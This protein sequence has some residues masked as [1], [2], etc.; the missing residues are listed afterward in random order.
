[1]PSTA[2]G[3]QFD[4]YDLDA[5]YEVVGTS[6]NYSFQYKIGIG[7]DLV[8]NPN[9]TA[10]NDENHFETVDQIV[11]LRGNYG[12]FEIRIFAVSN[13]GVRSEFIQDSIFI[14]PPSFDGTFTFNNLKINDLPE[15]SNL[16]NEIT[17]APE[18][19]GSTLEVSS[20]FINR[21]INL[22]WELIPPIGHEL[23]GE[24]VSDKLLSDDFFDHFKIK[25][26]NGIDNTVI[27]DSN[28]NSSVSLQ[29]KLLTANVA[30][31]LNFYRDFSIELDENTFSAQEL[32]LERNLSFEI[33]AHDSRGGVCTGIL[34]GINF[35]PDLNAT[36]GLSNSESSFSFSS[37]DTDF[38]SVE[39]RYIGIP[40]DFGLFDYRDIEN[41]VT[42][43]TRLNNAKEYVSLKNQRFIKN[44]SFVLFEGDVYKAIQTHLNSDA[45]SPPNTIYWENVG[46]KFAFS[47]GVESTSSNSF[48]N[49]QIFGYDYYYSFKPFDGYGPNET[50]NFTEERNL[51]KSSENDGILFPVRSEIKIDSLSFREREDDL[52]FNWSIVDQDGLPVELADQKYL[53]NFGDTQK[54]LGISGHLFDNHNNE[55]LSGIAS[56]EIIDNFEYTRDINNQIYKNGGFPEN[57][58]DFNITEIYTPDDKDMVISDFDFSREYIGEDSILLEIIA[59]HGGIAG[60][61]GS[62]NNKFLFNSV[63]QNSAKQ[64]YVRPYYELWDVSKTYYVNTTNPLLTDI[65]AYQKTLYEAVADSGPESDD[66]IGIFNETLNYSQGDLVISPTSAVQI[67]DNTLSYEISETVL[68]EGNIYSCLDDQSIGNAID[69]DLDSTKWKLQSPF[70]DVPC[71]IY[72]AIFPVAAQSVT[73]FINSQQDQNSIVWVPQYPNNSDKFTVCV[74][75]YSDAP[76]N[77]FVY[78]DEMVYKRNN[79]SPST[80]PPI[81]LASLNQDYTTLDWTPFWEINDNFENVVFGHVGIPQSGKRSVGLEIGIVSV[82][83]QVVS[84]DQII[85]DNPAPVISN[86]GFSVDSQS[87]VTKVKFNFNYLRGR[88][89]KTTLLNLYRSDQPDF[90]ITG[91]DGLPFTGI[92]QTDSTFVKSVLGEGDATFGDNITQIVDDTA[93]VGEEITGYYYK[94]LPFDD[95]GSG[96][97]YTAVDDEDPIEKVWVLP[98]NFHDRR[99]GA[100]PGPAIEITTDEIPG[101]VGNLNGETAFENYFLNWDM[102]NG[103]IQNGIFVNDVPNDISYYE[104]WQSSGQSNNFLQFS[105]GSFLTEEQNATGYRRINVVPN[106]FGNNIPDENEDFANGIVNASNVLDID[107]R[108]RSIQVTHRGEVNDTSYFWVRPVDHAGNKGPFTGASDL[109]NTDN[110]EGLKLILGQANTTDIADFEQNISQS[111]PNTISL[112]PQNPFSYDASTNTTSWINHILYYDGVGYIV[113]AGTAVDQRYI[114][115]SSSRDG[116][117]YGDV[118]DSNNPEYSRN[119]ALKTA[120]GLEEPGGGAQTNSDNLRNVEKAGVYNSSDYHPAGAGDSTEVANGDPY[121]N[122]EKPNL[123][124]PEGDFI[125]ARIAGGTVTTMWHS[126]ANATIG[127]AHIEEAAITSA[128]VHTLTADKIRSAEIK[129]QDIQVGGTGQI[130]SVNFPGL[131]NPIQN[132]PQGFAVSGD[133]TFIFAA[134]DGRLHFDDGELVLEGKLRQ[135]DGKEYTFIDLDASPDSFFYNELS[136]GTFTP[137]DNTDVCN[138]RASFQNSFIQAD[139]VRFRVSNPNNGYEFIKYSDTGSNGGYNIS[140]FKYDPGND[141]VNGEPKVATGKFDITGFNE[142]INTVDPQLTTIIVSASGVNTSTERSIPINFV[143]DGAAAVYA[144]LKAQQQVYSYD[145]DGKFNDANSNLNLEATAHN[146]HGNIEFLFETGVNLDSSSLVEKH[147]VTKND[148]TASFQLDDFAD[149]ALQYYSNTP[150]VAKL[151]I[152]D[153]DENNNSR[154]LASDFVSIFGTLPGKDS[155]TVFLTNENHTY[156]ANENGF[157]SSSDLDVGKTQVRFFRGNQEYAFDETSPFGEN[158]FSLV[159]VT[160]SDSAV[161]HSADPQ[162]VGVDRKLFVKMAAYPDDK[163]EGTFTIKVKD[164]QYSSPDPEVT[165]EKIYT[166]SKSIEAAQGRTVD[167]SADAQAVKYDTAGGNP[168]K[169]SVKI[170]AFA[171]NFIAQAQGGAGN[172]EYEFFVVTEPNTSNIKIKNRGM[173]NTVDVAIPTTHG[174]TATTSTANYSLPVTIECKAYDTTKNNNVDV[175]DTNPRAT[176]QITIFGLK[177]GSNAITVIQSQQ[178]VNVPV[179]NDSTGAVTDVDVSNTKNILTVFDGTNALNANV[180]P[181]G[182]STDIGFYVETAHPFTNKLTTLVDPTKPLEFSSEVNEWNIT[183]DSAEITYTITIIDNDPVSAQTKIVTAKQ[184]LVKTFDGTIAR[185]V[186]LTGDQAVHYNTAGNS[187]NPQAILLTATALNAS[188]GSSFKYQYTLQNNASGTIDKSGYVTSNTVTYTPNSVKFDVDTVTVEISENNGTNVLATDTLSIYGIQDG[189]DVVTAILSNE[190]HSLTKNSQGTITSAGSG[191]DIKVFQGT[192]ELSVN[193]SASNAGDLNNNEFLVDI[194]DINQV[195]EGS[196]Q[197]GDLNGYAYVTRNQDL[198]DFYNNNNQWAGN[199]VQNLS[200]IEFGEAHFAVFPNGTQTKYYCARVAN[201]DF[202]SF[203]GQSATIAYTIT[204]KNDVGETGTIIKQQTFSISEQG[205]KGNKGVG[206]V[207]RG[208]WAP[209]KIYTGATETSD[210]GDVVYYP[211]GTS[212]YWIAQ[213]THTS[214][215]SFASDEAGGKWE[216]F[217]AEFESVATDL[218]LAKDAVIT[219]TLTMGEGDTNSGTEYVGHGGLIKTV[220]KEFGNGVTGFFLGNTGNPPNPQFDVGGESSFI[221]FDGDSDRVEI[222]GSLIINSRD[223]T[224][225]DIN[226]TAGEDATFIGGGYNNFITG[227]QVGESG[228]ASSIVGGGNNNISGRFSFIGGGFDNNLGDNFS[229]IVAG[230]NNEMPNLESGN[231]GANFIGAGVKNTIDGGTNQSI[232]NGFENEIF[233]GPEDITIGSSNF[234]EIIYDPDNSLLAEGFLGKGKGVTRLLDNGCAFNTNFPTDGSISPWRNLFFVSYSDAG[235]IKSLEGLNSGFWIYTLNFGYIFVTAEK[236]KIFASQGDRWSGWMYLNVQVHGTSDSLGWVFFPN[237]GIGHTQTVAT[238]GGQIDADGVT[239]S[240]NKALVFASSYYGGSFIFVCTNASYST[241]HGKY[242]YLTYSDYVSSGTTASS[243]NWQLLYELS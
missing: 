148:G 197:N 20:E 170:S 11:P 87:E 133:G 187:P 228:F 36:H 30:G 130:R 151:T 221:R 98:R 72:K 124:E 242:Y 37:L 24:S 214:S 186:D 120:L 147:R 13:I 121:N 139:Q 76:T 26:K 213:E 106:T 102:P 199:P 53:I 101:P 146:T 140:G 5:T 1:M 161:T 141:F 152:S 233:F 55:F 206:V 23:E 181:V 239:I 189:S 154:E 195:T 182:T 52:V 180:G 113:E 219:H 107:A 231:A 71:M 110:V 48:V 94:L 21:N 156:P 126:F 185:K 38:A 158:T 27:S 9:D 192:K 90:E 194:Q 7:R 84:K 69:P 183:E 134:D 203:T 79:S 104:V 32:N 56:E 153:K 8:E 178:F 240:S 230:Y 25:I 149:H 17:K 117:K 173:D 73:P 93:E 227:S 229:T 59:N 64:P 35:L 62:S 160:S 42:Y 46:P 96:A 60:S 119:Q 51:V 67:F 40:N 193:I 129:G 78:F 75:S 220:G 58:K 108:S 211:H 118:N 196:L 105:D 14:A 66:D 112:I 19:P 15:N 74:P 81:P 31:K 116:V 166:Y 184:N 218:L 191:T 88:E 208:L 202:S 57:A 10:W 18:N 12:S 215:A 222:K 95:F 63:A 29:E 89:E 169:T 232:V 80:E 91:S 235:E 16:N 43:F 111:F 210:R 70:S 28:L 45:T 114:Y 237:P 54:V 223:Y 61:I 49:T 22:S 122:N 164:N 209:N 99:R 145:Y 4:L 132:Q 33:T 190:A 168:T 92:N 123:L 136:D 109:A 144:E 217:G 176:D 103:Q 200:L 3:I 216:S 34:T 234:Q 2:I 47:H 127:T 159:S 165:F 85:G 77:E 198:L 39:A 115:W 179:K 44:E 137:D 163:N 157:V 82:D 243:Y 205:V 50:F 241:G 150:F 125:I 68:F 226:S 212:E 135:I 167:L 207:F 238:S 162:G 100:P 175:K 174:G 138:I 6:D 225:L 65:V 224:N 143:A 201:H 177:E 97:L 41:N 204:F 171:T 188:S 128:K 83:G 142:M 172:V 236:S 155:Y 131:V 86:N